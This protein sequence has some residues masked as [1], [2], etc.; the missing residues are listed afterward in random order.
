VNQEVWVMR[1]TLLNFCF[2][3]GALVTAAGTFLLIPR[4]LRPAKKCSFQ[5]T[6]DTASVINHKAV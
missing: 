6:L 1:S 3:C 4:E 2:I 5:H